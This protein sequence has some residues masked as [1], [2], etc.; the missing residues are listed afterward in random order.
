[1]IVDQAL[2]ARIERAEGAFIAACSRAIESRHGVAAFQEPVA[3]GIASYAGPES[4]FNK[5][6]GT[7]FD[8][9][10]STTE[11][12]SIEERYDTVGAAV[13]F[14]ISTLGD[15]EIFELL[16]ARG[17]LL[18]SF[19]DVLVC[20]LG[21]RR[22]RPAAGIEVRRAEDELETWMAIAVESALRGDTAGVP[23]HDTFPRSALET[24][25]QAGVDAGAQAFMALLDGQPAGSGGL[26]VVGEIAQLT[27]AGTLPEHRRRGVQTALVQA[28]LA[29]AS[30]AGCSYAVVTT[31][32]GSTS[33]ANMRRAGFELGYTRAV[34]TR[35]VR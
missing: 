33:Q 6:A 7:G 22:P 34:L 21:D 13:S 8:G 31:Q 11:L 19:E 28:R 20:E 29:D 35:P 10:P 25:E 26:H 4:P 16:T 5:V 24:A 14:E 3:G 12:S 23:Q 30:A 27:G 32:P 2:A 15:P 9:L 1:M 18:V 17:Y